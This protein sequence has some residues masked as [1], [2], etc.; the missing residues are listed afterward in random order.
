MQ[1]KHIEVTFSRAPQIPFYYIPL[2]RPSKF[3]V[4]PCDYRLVLGGYPIRGFLSP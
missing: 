1:V 4:I 3:R 2:L